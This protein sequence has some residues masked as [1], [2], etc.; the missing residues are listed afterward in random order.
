M[1]LQVAAALCAMPP[2]VLTA[3]V[4]DT[5]FV[6]SLCGLS[7][8]PTAPSLQGP[9]ARRLRAFGVRLAALGGAAPPGGE[10]GP[11]GAQ[12]LPASGAR[13]SRL[14]SHRPHCFWPAGL[15][16]FAIVFFVPAALQ[17]AALRA[18]VARWG[19]AGRATPHTTCLSGDA[20]VFGVCAFGAAAFVF[21]LWSMFLSKLL[22]S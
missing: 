11:L 15:S 21:N 7:A 13:A 18:S 1:R 22:A 19:R 16:G 9:H 5:A 4:R 10:T 20:A 14:Q 3:L 12:P 2:L 6:F 17:R 8:W